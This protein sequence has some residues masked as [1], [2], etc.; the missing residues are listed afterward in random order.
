MDEISRVVSHRKPFTERGLPTW[1]RLLQC[2]RLFLGL[3]TECANPLAP[4]CRSAPRIDPASMPTEKRYGLGGVLRSLVATISSST[5]R[6]RR[7]LICAGEVLRGVLLGPAQLLF[8]RVRQFSAVFTRPVLHLFSGMN[9]FCP[10]VPDRNPRA[11]SKPQNH[12]HVRRLFHIYV[13][14]CRRGKRF[15]G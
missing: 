13:M 11:E 3:S 14:P 7:L 6:M 10:L 9:G 12:N 8:R 2:Q 15:W 5:F 1:L 4:A